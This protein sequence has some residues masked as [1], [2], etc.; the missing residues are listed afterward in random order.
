MEEEKKQNIRNHLFIIYGI[1]NS[2]FNGGE[3]PVDLQI[4]DIE[5]A[6]DALWLEDS[7]NN[8]VDTLPLDSQDDKIAL[9][10]EGNRYN[11]VA[12]NTAVGQTDR[13]NI[14]EI[15]TQGGTWG[16]MLSSHY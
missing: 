8:M 15:V 9:I 10:Y 2:V 4:Y 6:F 3:D 12:V 5:K 16:P 7:M 1:V 14:L 13:R 11:Q